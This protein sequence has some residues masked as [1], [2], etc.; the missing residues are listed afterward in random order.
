[1]TVTEH[2][3][4]AKARALRY[5]DRGELLNAHGSFISDLSKH[6]GLVGLLRRAIREGH[7]LIAGELDTPAAMRRW[8]ESFELFVC[9][10]C[11]AVSYNP[12]DIKQGYCGRC[13]VFVND[14]VCPRCLGSRQ[15]CNECGLDG[16][17]CVC[18]DATLPTPMP[19][20]VCA[21]PERAP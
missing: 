11:S 18:P 1:M 21:L 12:N 14:P 3:A 16:S 7:R 6:D 20:P 10:R 4:W 8:I 5:V 9:P 17:R 13:H 15:V 19:C 2:L